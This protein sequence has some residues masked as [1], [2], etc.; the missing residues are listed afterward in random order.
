M[1]SG[2]NSWQDANRGYQISSE[3]L[4]TLVQLA[5]KYGPINLMFF[6]RSIG[7]TSAFRLHPLDRGVLSRARGT[8]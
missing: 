3:D 1:F 6:L 8:S 5:G 4:Q 7:E 2:Q